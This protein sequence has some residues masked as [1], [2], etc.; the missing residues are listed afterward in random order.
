MEKPLQTAE[1]P[2][3]EPS[4]E[5]KEQASNPETDRLLKALDRYRNSKPRE[6]EP[7]SFPDEL[8]E[9]EID[10]A[11][12]E[13]RE[14]LR[15][16]YIDGYNFF[17]SASL[18]EERQAV[19]G[20]HSRLVE[21]QKLGEAT[22]EPFAEKNLSDYLQ[23]ISAFRKIVRDIDRDWGN[24]FLAFLRQREIKE[25]RDIRVEEEFGSIDISRIKQF[26]ASPEEA[27]EQLL[28]Q[29]PEL[30]EAYS[31]FYIGQYPNLQKRLKET[32][33]ALDSRTRE[34]PQETLDFLAQL[35]DS[36]DKIDSRLI[37]DLIGINSGPVEKDIDMEALKEQYGYEQF[38]YQGT[39]YELI[40]RFLK[41]LNLTD[42]DVLYDLGC[43][44]GRIPLY[45]AMTTYGKYRGI[46]IVPERVKEANAAKDK[47]KLDNVD[48]RQGNV[49]EQDYADGSVFFLFNPFTDETLKKVGEQLEQ[50]AKAKKIRVVSI[51]AST[52]Y[53]NSQNWLRP[54]ES[55]SK[56]RPWGLTIYES[57]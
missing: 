27:R 19:L 53:F 43:G 16:P 36:D 12:W 54:V 29:Y 37:D 8:D 15:N 5:N 44:Y 55:G 52:S 50:L 26:F 25:N 42:Q 47:F 46:E 17:G 57:V 7:M 3:Q 11:L 45:G 23:D 48:F 2:G 4:E 24:S 13:L 28:Q 14:K 39:P 9:I 18:A 32:E 22:P 56:E 34:H 6:Y 35:H 10:G 21:R 51:G 38:P 20:Y 31:R 41:E 33:Q 1:T 30:A 40:R 49:L